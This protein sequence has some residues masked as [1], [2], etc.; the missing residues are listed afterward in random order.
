MSCVSDHMSSITGVNV[1]SHEA[2]STNKFLTSLSGF[3]ESVCWAIH[4]RRTVLPGRLVAPGPDDD[5]LHSILDAAAAAPDH[6]RLLPWRFVL[7]TQPAREGLSKVFVDVL[8]KREPNASETNVMQA[9][10]RAHR[11]PVLLLA[12]VR[13]ADAESRIG[14]NER[15]VSAGCAI[16]NVL[17]MATALGF[18]SSLTTGSALQSQGLAEMFEL[19]SDEQ[20]LC[21]IN[22]GTPRN[23]K[24]LRIRATLDQYFSSL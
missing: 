20:A 7:V 5:Q 4:A 10:E 11:S 22:I 17:L 18:G 6:G 2:A 8:L 3:A 21:F 9:R 12:I 23:Q 15:F 13:L 19:L 14:N 1:S 24:P 16:Q